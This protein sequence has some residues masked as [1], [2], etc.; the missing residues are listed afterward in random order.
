MNFLLRQEML[1][2]IRGLYFC[3]ENKWSEIGKE[4]NI[5]PAQ[6]H[7]LFLLSVNDNELTPTKIGELGCWHTSTVTRLLKRLETS[8][9][10]NAK[11]N[12]KQARYKIVSMTAK[13]EELFKKLFNTAKGMKEFPFN[14]NHLSEDEILSFL[15][16]GKS[17]LDVHKG[18]DFRKSVISKQMDNYDYA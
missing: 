13:G 6:Q 8:G 17:I 12:P 15:E 11:T 14:M 4:Y 18:K 9:Y 5:T 16:C 10:T 1:L 3:M 7:I 2:M